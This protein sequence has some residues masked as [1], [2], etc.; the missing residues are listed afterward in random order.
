VAQFIGGLLFVPL[1]VIL[2]AWLSYAV[3][4]Y[5]L[6]ALVVILFRNKQS[7]R[8]RLL[9]RGGL[10]IAFGIM[11]CNFAFS[12]PWMASLVGMKTRI[13]AS[14]GYDTLR[15]FADEIAHDPDGIVWDIAVRHPKGKLDEQRREELSLQYP[16]LKWGL[17]RGRVFLDDNAVTMSWGRGFACTWGFE[18]AAHGV[19]PEVYKDG[20]HG[21][22]V[23]K[24]ADDIQFIWCE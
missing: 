10:V 7:G 21:V 9:A 2:M 20:I 12:E 6:I 8:T 17:G 5:S 18:V 19:V 4:L 14:V 24:V 16:F 11:F 22:S 15:S 23:L 3:W 13:S 1:L